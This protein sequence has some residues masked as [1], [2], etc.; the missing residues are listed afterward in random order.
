MDN[1]TRIYSIII[2]LAIAA[3]LFFWASS[4]DEPRV[5]ELDSILAADPIVSDYP[6]RFR[7][8]S[9]DNGVVTLS[10]PRSAAFPAVKF[11][12]IIDPKLANKAQDDPAMI[13]AQQELIDHQ[14][15]AQGLMLA[16]PDVASV[17]WELD[18]AWLAQ[19]GADMRGL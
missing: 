17:A 3:G 7:V 16:E 15:R 13:A 19:H 1:F 6:Y 11:L 9:F 5:G 12:P 2:G 10:S 18:S 4:G 14:K 8:R